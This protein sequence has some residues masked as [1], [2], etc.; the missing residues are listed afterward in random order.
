VL[1]SLVVAF[2]SIFLTTRAFLTGKRYQSFSDVALIAYGV[3]E[4]LRFEEQAKS[5][6]NVFV[7]PTQV[8]MWL[9]TVEV[10]AKW[11]CLGS[12]FLRSKFNV[13][14]ALVVI[15]TT[16]LDIIRMYCGLPR[17]METIIAVLRLL[18]LL[19][20]VRAFREVRIVLRTYVKIFPVYIR[21]MVVL[22]MFFYFFAVIGTSPSH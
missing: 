6:N 17:F 4:I 1:L 9:F 15:P 14:D 11:L 12:A 22:A 2:L 8:F 21:Y 20:V 5:N 19:R 10:A 18:R 16:I 13:F 3:V 7:L